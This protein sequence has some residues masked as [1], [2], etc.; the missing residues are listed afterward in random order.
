MSIIEGGGLRLAVAIGGSVR[1]RGVEV[2][3]M[4]A[5]DDEHDEKNVVGVIQL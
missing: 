4:N 5:D 2:S 3:W 1:H